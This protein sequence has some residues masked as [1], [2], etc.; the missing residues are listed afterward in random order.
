MSVLPRLPGQNIRNIRA[1]KTNRAV[2]AVRTVTVAKTVC[3]NCQDCKL[4]SVDLPQQQAAKVREAAVRRSPQ[5]RSVI[6]Q[7]VTSFSLCLEEEEEE[8][9]H[10][11]VIIQAVTSFSLCLHQQIDWGEE[12]EEDGE[13]K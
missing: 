10:R 1:F 4:D 12:E 8:E 3:Q 6:I 9:E 11:S 13:D 2:R 5:H 7:A